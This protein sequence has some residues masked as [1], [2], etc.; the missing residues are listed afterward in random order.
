MRYN[1]LLEDLGITEDELKAIK[2]YVMILYAERDMIKE[3]HILNL[4]GLI[5]GAVCRR[6]EGCSH[7]TIPFKSYAVERMRS[8]LLGK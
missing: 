3:D 1:M 7:M 4:A 2:T 6:I 8:Y 5:P